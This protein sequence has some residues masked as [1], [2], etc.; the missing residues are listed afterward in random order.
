MFGSGGS[1]SSEPR[2][3]YHQW[4]FDILGIEVPTVSLGSA[5]AIAEL[6]RSI[7][8]RLPASIRE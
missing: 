2:L 1:V 5:G 7:K 3:Q 8:A 6:E 4:T